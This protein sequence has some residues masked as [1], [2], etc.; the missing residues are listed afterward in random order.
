VEITKESKP[1]IRFMKVPT[2]NAIAAVGPRSVRN[3]RR[4]K[5][6]IAKMRQRR[7]SYLMNSTEA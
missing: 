7:Y 2:I 4:K 1:V 3:Q 5:A 6:I